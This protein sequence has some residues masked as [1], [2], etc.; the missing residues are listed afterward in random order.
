M[1]FRRSRVRSASAPPIKTIDRQGVV[2]RAT[3]AACIVSALALIWCHRFLPLSDYPD[4]IFEGSVVAKL[5]RGEAPASYTFKHYPV[6]YSAIVAMLGILDFVFSPEVSGKVVLS[7]CIL[8]LAVSSTYM[9]RSVAPRA[10]N[11]LLLIPLLFLPNTYFFWGELNYDLGLWLLFFYCG[12]LFRRV[13]RKEAINWPLVAGVFVALF[14]CHFLP[15]AIALLITLMFILTESRLDLLRPYGVCA[16]PSIGLTIWYAIERAEP[17][18]SSPIWMFWTPHQ[19][20]GRWLAAFSPYP[21]FLPWVSIH[22]PGMKFFALLNLFTAISLTLVVPA[23]VALW[24][25]GRT[26]NRG[27]LACAIV[28]GIAAIMCGY[29]FSGMVS[30][31]ERFFYPAVWLGLTWLLGEGL[32]GKKS[33][34]SG[35]VV[36]VTVG[37]VAIQ[38]AF[39]Q[40][41][42]GAVSDQLEALYSKLRLAHS[43]TELC[44]TY[45]TYLRQSWDQPHRTG[46]NVLLTNHASE[47][48]MPYYI[49]LERNVEAPIFQIGILNYAG[50]GNNED[51]CKSE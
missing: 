18:I 43:Q 28:C 40:I 11:P 41:K 5:V 46:L 49:Y 20:I 13:Y 42:V 44:A 1:A 6:P 7:L 30:P 45:E 27:V 23:C 35:S 10:S 29:E 47:P 37:L 12:Y 2:F 8:L 17:T 36:V 21:E 26:E 4:W 14:S 50:R 15:Y 9:L 22:S 48:R 31:G 51:L 16:A 24:L 33:I 25:K 39:L 34:L 3:F 19:F 38:I 32:P